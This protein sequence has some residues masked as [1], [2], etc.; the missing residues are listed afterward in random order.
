[1]DIAYY[2]FLRECELEVAWLQTREGLA[3]GSFRQESADE[4]IVRIEAELG[5]EL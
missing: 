4:H 1:V 2:E 5:D 3:A